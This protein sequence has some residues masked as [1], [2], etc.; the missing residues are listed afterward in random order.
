MEGD[1]RA[2]NQRI[3]TIRELTS[4]AQLQAEGRKMQHCV[5]T[6]LH[7]CRVGRASIWSLQ[8]EQKKG[9]I[10]MLTIQ[11]DIRLRRIV[12]VSGRRN[13]EPTELGRKVMARWATAAGLTIADWV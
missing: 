7:S 1:A 12:Q 3:W 8:V 9:P 2:G 4:G 5:A 10:R 11:V 6:Y 13:A